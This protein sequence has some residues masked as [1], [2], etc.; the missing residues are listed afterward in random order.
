MKS[1][2]FKSAWSIFRMQNVSFSEALKLAWKS[3]KSGLK[4]VI[5]KTNKLVKS[6]GLGYETISFNELVFTNVD[7][8]K[9]VYN[10]DGASKWYDGKTF[11]ND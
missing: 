7:I 4:A 8:I 3:I 6:S 5:V 10:N 9:S 1:L 11:N 2:L